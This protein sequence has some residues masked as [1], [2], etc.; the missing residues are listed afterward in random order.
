[1][2]RTVEIISTTT[3]SHYLLFG[4][5]A[6]EVANFSV[7]MW[8]EKH[9][10]RA[11]DWLQALSLGYMSFSGGNLYI[12]NSDAVPRCN[13]FGEQKDAKIGVVINEKATTTKVLDSLGIFTD[14]LWEVESLTIPVDLNYP[15]GMY[16]KIPSGNFKKREGVLYSEFMRNMKTSSE[17]PKTIEAISGEELRG[18]EAY[19]VLKHTGGTETQIWKID[20]NMTASR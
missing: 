8:I 2:A 12:H 1:V 9:G 17:T 15:N 3:G 20:F 7:Q 14:G 11:V 6:S 4:W 13:L 19:L 16:S 10:V 5:N 18:N